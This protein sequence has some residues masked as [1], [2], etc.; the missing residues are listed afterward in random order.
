MKQIRQ[1]FIWKVSRL[2]RR[3]QV[4]AWIHKELPRYPSYPGSHLA[5][6][7][8]LMLVPVKPTPRNKIYYAFDVSEIKKGPHVL[9]IVDKKGEWRD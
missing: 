2:T 4:T 6:P 5:V 7:H 1:R 9:G 3:K 8:W